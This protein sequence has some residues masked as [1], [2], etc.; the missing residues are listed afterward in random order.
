MIVL[1]DDLQ[2]SLENLFTGPFDLLLHLVRRNEIDLMEIPVAY[3]VEEYLRA[4]GAMEQL[5]IEIAGEFLL[6]AAYLV[7]WKARMLLPV[8]Q[9]DGEQ[10]PEPEPFSQEWTERLMRY[11]RYRTAA[12]LLLERSHGSVWPRG[13]SIDIDPGD[14]GLAPMKREDLT[15]VMTGLMKVR[16]LRDSSRYVQLLPVRA[17]MQ[18]ILRVVQN[19]GSIF[20]RQVIVRPRRADAV[21]AFLAVLELTVMGFVTLVGDGLDLQIHKSD[22]ADSTEIPDLLQETVSHGEA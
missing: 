9:N 16:K 2:I 3:L 17:A 4:I 8:P 11:H 10:P 14:P 18:R 21:V 20:L 15:S 6:M 19:R 12:G 13:G 7:E 22:A 5:D 1:S